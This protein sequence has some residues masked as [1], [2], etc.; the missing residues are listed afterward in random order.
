M[1]PPPPP[2]APA[3]PIRQNRHPPR[4][5]YDTPPTPPPDMDALPPPPPRQIRHQ[6]ERQCKDKS[7]PLSNV[8]AFSNRPEFQV[9]RTRLLDN[10]HA[11]RRFHPC[12]SSIEIDHEA[13]ASLP[14]NGSVFDLLRSTTTRNTTIGTDIPEFVDEGREDIVLEGIVPNVGSGLREVDETRAMLE[15]MDEAT[16]LAMTAPPLRPTPLYEHDKTSQHLINAFPFLFPQGL[17]DLHA[18]RQNKVSPNDYFKHLMKYEDGRF[19]AHP[20]FR[21]YAFNALLRWQ[22]RALAGYYQ[23][24]ESDSTELARRV[25]RTASTLR[26]TPPYW[27]ARS[28]E[29]KT[30]IR[31]LKTPHAFITLSAADLQWADLHSHMSGTHTSPSDETMR[32]RLNSLN[33]NANPAQVA[34]WIQRRATLFLHHVITPL[35]K[36]KDFW[37]RYEWQ[38]RGSGHIHGLLWL[39]DGPSVEGLKQGGDQLKQSF[40]DYWKDKVSAINPS[41][42]LPRASK[43]PSSRP[44]EDMTYDHTSL[45]E[46]LNRIQRHTR[47]SQYCLKRPK[48]SEPTAEPICR[49]RF[50]RPLC[51]TASLAPNDRDILQLS[52]PR[53]DPLLNLYNPVFTLGWQANVD[54][55]PCTDPH[56]VATY[57]A[58]YASKAEKPSLAFGDVMQAIANQVEDETPSRAVFQKMLSKVVTERDYSAQEVCHSLLDCKMMSSSRDFRTLCL[59]P[60]R[61]RRLQVQEGEQDVE[62]RD[63]YDMYLQ[64]DETLENINLYQ[65]YKRYEKRHGNIVFR[66]KNDRIVRLWPAYHPSNSDNEEY[67][68]WCRAKIILHHPHRN[69]TEL[70]DE[71]ETWGLGYERCKT[72][73]LDGH[74]DTLPA[75]GWR[76][77]GEEVDEEFSSDEGDEEEQVLE[78]WH[79]MCQEGGSHTVQLDIGQRLGLRDMDKAEDWHKATR[80]WGV[81]GLDE[82]TKALEEWKKTSV[83]TASRP[84]VNILLLNDTQKRVHSKVMKHAQAWQNGC[85]DPPFLLNIDGTAGTGKSFLIDAISQSLDNFI[86][87]SS[88]VKRLAPTGV[89]AFNIAGQTYHSALGLSADDKA[90]PVGLSGARLATLQEEWKMVKYL[91]LDEK[92]MIGR[93]ALGRIHT[94][95]GFIFPASSHLPFGGLSVLLFGDFGQLPPVG[96]TPLYVTM[97]R[98]GSSSSSHLQNKGLEVYR[99]FKESIELG[100]VMRQV[101]E[102]TE[103]LGFRA[104][105]SHLRSGE[106]SQQDYD[107][108]ATRFWDRLGQLEQE[109]YATAVNLCSEKAR[110]AEINVGRLVKAGAPVLRVQARHTGVQAKKGTE[111][112]AEGLSRVLHLMIGAEVMLTR[113]LWTSQGLVNGTRG[114]VH[115][116]GL[117]EG[118]EAGIDLP[119]VV[120]VA[121]PTYQGQTSWRDEVGT[122]LLPITPVTVT[123]DG[124]AGTTCSRT[125][126]PL[127]LAYAITIHKSQGMTLDRA[128]VDIGNRE[129]ATGLTFVAA[130]RVRALLGLAFRPGFPIERIV[131]SGNERGGAGAARRM[132]QEDEVRRR[133]LRFLE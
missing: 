79:L 85:P 26:G 23:L 67:E 118:D 82:R 8:T 115:S 55:Q 30:M 91:I 37:L 21:Y 120:M 24:L 129:F 101:G 111:E 22:A 20:R 124:P 27:A 40:I 104:T 18:T 80:E 117:R 61:A 11:L 99:Q 60:N 65:W 31:Q 17:A 38:S 127:Q 34:W 106:V 2:L 9:S 6:G 36:V 105:L 10:L 89:A 47:C 13:L 28:Q 132:A 14:E 29:L 108:L 42:D 83:A 62:D 116:I 51:T 53:N 15:E 109:Q 121:F 90:R 114:R 96:D 49:F 63:W 73:H 131:R 5:P 93:K 70:L 41:I 50:P 95:L 88:C 45:A 48:G 75:R 112:K 125:Q 43:H 84:P 59:L 35:L 76:Q 71:G 87:P 92:S 100:Q 56:A 32:Q 128:C 68:M 72:I 1:R 12:Y 64:R 46:H 66:Q 119:S 126:F 25:R 69:E 98:E 107:R 133:G 57:V 113:N 78:D 74:E 54:I 19:A 103:S 52:I 3:R 110:V 102:D 39:E 77:G 86:S 44:H 130:S 4:R 16:R 33:V 81:D 94:Q 58:K 122:P 7:T 123:W 97:W